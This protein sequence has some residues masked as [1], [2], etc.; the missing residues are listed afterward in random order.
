MKPSTAVVGVE[1]A[2][3][4]EHLLL[5]G[6]GRKAVIDRLDPHLRTVLVLVADVDERGGIIS[7]EYGR[8]RDV[9][10]LA[11][12]LGDSRAH[13]RGKLRTVHQRRR[14]GSGL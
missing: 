4:R 3:E 10:E 7:D 9:T 14:H 13:A 6:V 12:L 5:A 11:D 1:L 8:Q 2:H